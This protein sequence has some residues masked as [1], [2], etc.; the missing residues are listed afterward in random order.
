MKLATTLRTTLATAILC[1][2]AGAALAQ[3]V[4]EPVGNFAGY[5]VHDY[6][7]STTNLQPNAP[8][9]V[10]VV[11]YDNTTSPAN[12]GVS[13]TDL[14]A[15]WGDELITTNTGTL[16][17][18]MF[19]LFN[20]GSSAGPLLTA[21]VRVDFFDASTLAALGSFTTNINFGAGLNAGFY[22]LITVTGLEPLT[23]NLAASPLI[24]TQTVLATTGTA[25]R[26]GV[27]SLNPVTVGSSLPDMYIDASTIGPAGWY[28]FGAPPANPAYQVSVVTA[29]VPTGKSSWGAVKN[30]YR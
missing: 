9:A 6:V 21:Q 12:F 25:N 19:S 8:N 20:A 15:D 5:F 17:G 3:A 27:A 11:I 26:L 24:V 2:W 10:P 1:A 4:A 7:T 14:T 23:I 22:S 30:L 29:P 13:S 28:T 18:F 16:S